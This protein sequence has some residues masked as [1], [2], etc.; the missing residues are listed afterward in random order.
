MTLYESDFTYREL[1]RTDGPVLL[2][3]ITDDI[4]EDS[5]ELSALCYFVKIPERDY[6]IQKVKVKDIRPAFT[7]E[8][9]AI[10]KQ[11]GLKTFVSFEN[12]VARPYAFFRGDKF[13]R[14]MGATAS[15]AIIF[16]EEGN[17]L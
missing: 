3:T 17:Q 8:D 16:D 4:D 6:A 9:L 12:F 11:K 1:F 10:R 2:S 5:Q 14:G 7:K 13:L 15:K